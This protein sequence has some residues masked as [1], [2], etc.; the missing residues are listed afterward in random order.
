MGDWCNHLFIVESNGPLLYAWQWLDFLGFSSSVYSNHS[1]IHLNALNGYCCLTSCPFYFECSHSVHPTIVATN[2]RSRG[3]CTSTHTRIGLG[4]LSQDI[5]FLLPFLSLC[6]ELWK[7]IAHIR[8]I[9][10]QRMLLIGLLGSSLLHCT[11]DKSNI[12]TFLLI[13]C[14]ACIF[15]VYTRTTLLTSCLIY[16]PWIT[17]VFHITVW[18]FFLLSYLL[19]LTA[20]FQLYG[21]RS[22]WTV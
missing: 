11:F 16:S 12:S 20:L 22:T 6:L 15:S 19:Q 14:L 18:P 5:G 7:H 8:T 13:G 4:F 3:M 9:P 10:Q 1:L 2:S 21:L 17:S